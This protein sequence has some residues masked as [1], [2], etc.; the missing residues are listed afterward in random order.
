[1]P[2]ATATAGHRRVCADLAGR[3][4]PT[5][6]LPGRGALRPRPDLGDRPAG[7]AGGDGAGPAGDE[8]FPACGAART[9]VPNGATAWPPGH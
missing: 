7:G 8:P 9:A 4:A 6:R 3:P 5:P 1:M 2:G